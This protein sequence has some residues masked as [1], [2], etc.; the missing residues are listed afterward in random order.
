MSRL[1]G[2][3]A[4]VS[5]AWLVEIEDAYHAIAARV[6]LIAIE[7]EGQRRG[8]L[9]LVDLVVHAVGGSQRARAGID[10]VDGM[11]SPAGQETAGGGGF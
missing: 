1:A 2:G 11:I 10:E 5:C 9:D 8:G 7:I 4:G 3:D 6:D